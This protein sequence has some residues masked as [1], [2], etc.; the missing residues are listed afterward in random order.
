MGGEGSSRKGKGE[1]KRKK[2]L[3]KLIKM[4]VR[5]VN[6]REKKRARLAS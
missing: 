2:M 3:D 6:E 5:C 4:L 1:R